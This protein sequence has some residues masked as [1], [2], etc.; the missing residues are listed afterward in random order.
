MLPTI[1]TTG[2]ASYAVNSTE[3]KFFTGESRGSNNASTIAFRLGL[4]V[5]WTAFDGFRMYVARDRFQTLEEQSRMRTTAAIQ[6][7]A[8]DILLNYYDLVQLE[9]STENLPTPSDWIA[10]CWIWSRTKKR[11]GTATGLELLQSRARLTPTRSF[12]INWKRIFNGPQNFNQ[13][14]NR[15][16]ETAFLWI[17]PLRALFLPGELPTQAFNPTQPY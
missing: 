1:G 9:R 11:I 2:T 7:L 15:P 4:E 16:V 12:W 6:A 13:L 8:A 10:I 5:S 3:Q 14:L 17:R